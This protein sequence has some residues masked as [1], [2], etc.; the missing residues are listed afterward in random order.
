MAEIIELFGRAPVAV[1][2]RVSPSSAKPTMSIFSDD[3]FS[4]K[5]WYEKTYSTTADRASRLLTDLPGYGFYPE[6]AD[7]DCEKYAEKE[8]G[9]IIAVRA[10]PASDA[11]W[12]VELGYYVVV[13]GDWWFRRRPEAGYEK[14]KPEQWLML[15]ANPEKYPN[16]R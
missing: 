16:E 13:H 7:F 1:K 12:T 9:A 10:F 5:Q 4:A 15:K 14:V 6:G 3:G 11:E 8:H 2:P